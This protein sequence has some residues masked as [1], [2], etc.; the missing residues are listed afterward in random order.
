MSTDQMLRDVTFFVIL[1]GFLNTRSKEITK[2]SDSNMSATVSLAPGGRHCRRP[3]RKHP[4]RGGRRKQ[5]RT[6]PVISSDRRASQ[7]RTLHP[8][9]TPT[10]DSAR[11]LSVECD[12]N[13]DSAIC[14]SNLIKI[15]ATLFTQE[16]SRHFKVM[17]LNTQSV[18][19]K[20]TDICDHVMHA[21]VDLIFLCEMWLRPEGDESDCV[22]LT[23]PGF[24]LRC[25]PR[26][27]GVGG[28]LAV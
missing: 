6:I 24:C 7:P 17:F 12:T 9:T 5:G 21:N 4:Y 13:S 25:F 27:S 10:F 26:M 15:N 14:Y 8:F 28:G 19:N 18:R 11:R 16:L 1:P 20:T 2:W 3:A 22:A 23:S